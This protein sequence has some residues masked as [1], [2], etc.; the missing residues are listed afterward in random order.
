M[1]APWWI[2]YY[3]DGRA[4][5][6]GEIK[7]AELERDNIKRFILLNPFGRKI[8]E[9]EPKPGQTL[10]FRRRVAID[11]AGNVRK[12]IYVCGYVERGVATLFHVDMTGK[13]VRPPEIGPYM[14]VDISYTAE[15]LE[16]IRRNLGG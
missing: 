4:Y 7:Y 12:M 15:E 13:L 2:V 5:C 8:F 6:R 1:S 10:I 16:H 3:K 11:F 9:I 14:A